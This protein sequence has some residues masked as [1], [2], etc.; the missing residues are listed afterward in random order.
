[1]SSV[2]IERLPT[3]WLQNE[4]KRA[5]VTQIRRCWKFSNPLESFWSVFEAKRCN[6]LFEKGYAKL[7]LLL[8]SWLYWNLER[9]LSGKYKICIKN[10]KNFYF[11]TVQ[12]QLEAYSFKSWTYLV[13]NAHRYNNFAHVS[14]VLTFYS[15]KSID[16]LTKIE[17]KWWKLE[18]FRIL[19]FSMSILDNFCLKNCVYRF[20]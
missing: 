1:M 11:L 6:V 2:F 8:S 13:T 9:N 4:S 17:Q 14:G 15:T 19:S 10:D 5:K 12:G 7:P 18:N 20:S 16:I 3:F